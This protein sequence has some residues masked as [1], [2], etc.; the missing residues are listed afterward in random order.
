MSVR[1]RTQQTGSRRKCV[2]AGVYAAMK[3]TVIACW[4]PYTEDIRGHN[5]FAYGVGLKKEKKQKGATLTHT[6]NVTLTLTQLLFTPV[7]FLV[8][9]Y[10]FFIA[11]RYI[12]ARGIRCATS[13]RISTSLSVAYLH[14]CV[15][16]DRDVVLSL[17][18]GSDILNRA[19]SHDLEWP[20]VLFG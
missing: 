10:G 1:M 3:R 7:R 18:I 16:Q 6:V 14:S 9:P 2:L 11:R 20:S 4:H 19:I 5:S 12:H 17:Q 8:T 15:W 13:V